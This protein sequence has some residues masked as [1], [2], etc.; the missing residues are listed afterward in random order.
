MSLLGN[1][2]YN[3]DAS[4]ASEMM[5]YLLKDMGIYISEAT[6]QLL[7][8]GLYL[9][10][11]GLYYITEH[12]SFRTVT[13][14]LE[15]CANLQD[16]QN[17]FIIYNFEEHRK[18][19]KLVND[20]IDH[21]KFY[22][23]SK[24]RRCAIA[25]NTDDVDTIYTH[26]QLAEACDSLLQYPLDAAF[27]IGFIDKKSLGVDH[28][29]KISIKARSKISSNEVDVSEIMQLFNGGGDIN[30]AACQLDSSNIIAVKEALKSVIK[31]NCNL[32]D[33]EQILKRLV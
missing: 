12:Y 15:Y 27:V 13:K 26:E 24:S 25:I 9:D 23:S 6:A 32:K 7:L 1:L 5:F 11:N 22:N 33:K 30:R 20:L 4:S 14:L 8:A 17:L 3:L 19:K 18:Q 16:V 31:E 21:T 28:S 29:D 2:F 10:T